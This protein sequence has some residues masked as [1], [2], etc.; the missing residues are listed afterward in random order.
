MRVGFSGGAT[1]PTPLLFRNCKVG[2]NLVLNDGTFRQP[3][4][5]ANL[6]V[7][8][9]A[10]RSALVVDSTWS[11][12]QVVTV[13]IGGTLQRVELGVERAFNNTQPLMVDI[14]KT[15]GAAPDFT[16]AGR[17][18]TRTVAAAAIPQSVP[19]AQG[20]FFTTSVDVFN[21]T[22]AADTLQVARDVELP[23]FGRP[24]ELV[25]PRILR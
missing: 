15:I 14:V 8:S 20:T 18:A 16:I 7:A 10:S 3:H 23:A 1:P 21:A 24:R 13:G 17:L 12:A 22:D 25:R 2:L 4:D 6:A 11:A 5:Q 19:L 9:P